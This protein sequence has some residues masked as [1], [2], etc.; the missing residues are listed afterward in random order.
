MA[1]VLNDE[2][3]MLRDA[4]RAFLQQ[5][6][7]VGHLRALRDEGHAEGFSRALWREMA[8]LGWAG[9]G[10][11][12][13]H[14]GMGLGAA[15]LGVL[16]EECGRTLTPSPLL[17]TSLVGVTALVRSGSEATCARLL[18][19]VA[20]GEHLLA[21]ACDETAQHA[22]G[23]VET[24]AAKCADGYRITGAKVAVADGQ[25]A[26]TLLVSARVDGEIGVFMVP[27][28]AEGVAVTPYPVLDTHRAANIGFE[29]VSVPA[30][31]LLGSPQ[32]GRRLLDRLLDVGRIGVA[33]ELLGVAREAFERT[34]AYLRERKQFGVAIGSFQA[35]QHRAARLHCE[36]ELGQSVVIKAQQAVDADAADC[37]ELASLAKARLAET[38]QLSTAEAIQMHGGIGMTDEFDIGFFL[39]RYRVL[40]SLFGDRY[41]HLD[42]YARLRGY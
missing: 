19:A 12:E 24:E 39:K 38:A 32:Q 22:P 15:A 5:Q 8:E 13:A 29:Q 30:D 2:L 31:A 34:L 40:D 16:L 42:R 27:A 41:Y 35:L 10:V 1:L 20:R 7:P 21:L 11:P 9:I 36:I 4:A 33:S 17:N 26:D 14:D 6:A 18:P 23:R 25:V 37:A 28:Q 3:R